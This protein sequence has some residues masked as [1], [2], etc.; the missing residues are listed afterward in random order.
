MDL[1]RL[2]P[3]AAH[4]SG[5]AVAG[6]PGDGWRGD[7]PRLRA[8]GGRYDADRTATRNHAF[9]LPPERCS[10]HGCTMIGST[11][12]GN[13][14]RAGGALLAVAAGPQAQA[15]SV[16]F[17]TDFGFHGRHAYYY[18]ALDRGY[19][20]EAGL[21]ATIVRGS[22]SADAIRKGGAGAAPLGF[23]DAGSLVLARAN[24]GLPVRMI[25]VIYA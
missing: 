11:G 9:G 15:E 2:A 23:A 19:Y 16:T 5:A 18:V 24:D 4:G 7:D 3:R 20:K 21:D 12:T 13:L 1:R 8:S 6:S 14:I 25:A 22:G 17:I 10:E